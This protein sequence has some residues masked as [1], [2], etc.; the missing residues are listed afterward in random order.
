MDHQSE[1]EA[2]ERAIR[3]GWKEEG[4]TAA[5]KG[6]VLWQKDNTET[7]ND[8][9]RR[10]DISTKKNRR[11]EA[12]NKYIS[13]RGNPILADGSETKLGIW[14]RVLWSAV[15]MMILMGVILAKLLGYLPW[16]QME[17]ILGFFLVC[18][19]AGMLGYKIYS[20]K[21]KGRETQSPVPHEKRPICK[22]HLE[23][24]KED[25]SRGYL[26]RR[27]FDLEEEGQEISTAIPQG[28][29]DEV[30][31]EQE[32]PPESCGETVI[33]SE[34]TEAGPASL[35]SREPGELATI[36]LKEDLTVIGKLETAADAVIH[37]P[38]VSRVH[39]KIRKRDGKYYLSDLNSRN[40]TSVN[41]RILKGEEECQLQDQ[42]EVDFAQARYVF[43]E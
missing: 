36:F 35:V 32:E 14:K 22:N 7:G 27:D 33:L 12:G 24:R 39:A 40:G 30:Y 9:F 15:G 11:E 28:R 26:Y 23:D 18:M 16:V 34:N 8:Y 5:D 43:L 29:R 31:G 13:K 3:Q 38:T 1:T 2:E 19:G 37:L 4:Q 42:D 6:A 17:S 20:R 25:V 41:G 21:R 10:E